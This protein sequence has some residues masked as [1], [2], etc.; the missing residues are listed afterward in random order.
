MKLKSLGEYRCWYGREGWPA[1]RGQVGGCTHTRSGHVKQGSGDKGGYKSKEKGDVTGAAELLYYTVDIDETRCSHSHSHMCSSSRQRPTVCAIPY[2][3]PHW[4]PLAGK[5][6]QPVPTPVSINSKLELTH[7]R[8]SSHVAC[9]CRVWACW[10]VGAVTLSSSSVALGSVET[11]ET[12]QAQLRCHP[13][14]REPWA[15]WGYVP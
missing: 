1:C 2:D 12:L 10:E 9:R 15:D 13:T 6:R 14:C 7:L 5:G 8:T 11:T 3:R 4:V